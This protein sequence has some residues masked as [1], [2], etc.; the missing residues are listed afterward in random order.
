MVAWVLCTDYRGVW[1][2]RRL[3][4]LQAVPVCHAHQHQPNGGRTALHGCRWLTLSGLVSTS[5]MP[6][7]HP[8][9]RSVRSGLQGGNESTRMQH[10]Q[11]GAMPVLSPVHPLYSTLAAT[12]A[13]A[14]TAP[15]IIL[16]TASSSPPTSECFVS[17][18][19]RLCRA[20]T[21]FRLRFD[22]QHHLLTPFAP[23]RSLPAA[24][25]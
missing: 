13:Q 1:H 3:D 19:F 18:K 22:P 23:R 15:P 11:T 12:L 8:R 6:R 2:S 17:E 16:R 7:V 5:V 21:T 25:R 24:C 20:D 14:T 10:I 4:R 9:I